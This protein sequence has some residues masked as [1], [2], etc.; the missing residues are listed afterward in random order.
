[1]GA[2]DRLGLAGVSVSTRLPRETIT[3]T[4][5]GAYFTVYA[6][7]QP[8][9]GSVSLSLDGVVKQNVSLKSTASESASFEVTAAASA[10]HTI[11]IRTLNPGT[12]RIF[13]ITIECNRAGVTYDALGINGARASRFFRWNWKSFEDC[14]SRRDPDLIV[15]AYGSN[16]VGDQNLDFQRYAVM[17]T[18]L[19]RRLR[20]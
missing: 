13:G 2:D 10:I 14:L 16:E 18:T 9:G 1:L 6:L 8:G 15:V 11:Q 19:L 7:K 17:L 20:E 5:E 3:L 12:V 4:A